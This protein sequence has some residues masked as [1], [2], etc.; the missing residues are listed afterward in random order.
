MEDQT[1]DTPFLP[2]D[3]RHNKPTGTGPM[4]H[5]P[6][7]HSMRGR[8]SAYPPGKRHLKLT[9]YILVERTLFAGFPC[10]LGY[11]NMD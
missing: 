3:C 4:H 11:A 9:G 2:F 6:R 8:A 5:N 1:I 10:G 7:K